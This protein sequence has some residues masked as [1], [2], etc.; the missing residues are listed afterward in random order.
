MATLDNPLDHNKISDQHN[1]QDDVFYSVL[2]YYKIKG[3]GDV[4]VGRLEQG[5]LKSGFEFQVL[6]VSDVKNPSYARVKYIEMHHQHLTKTHL[7]DF[8][9]KKFFF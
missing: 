8:I 3:I 7:N 2:D 1:E 5:S 9:G 6:P 4:F